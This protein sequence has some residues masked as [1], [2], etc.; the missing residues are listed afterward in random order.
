MTFDEEGGVIHVRLTPDPDV[1][2]TE[3]AHLP[4]LVLIRLTY[5]NLRR[6]HQ[7]R[8]TYGPIVTPLQTFRFRSVLKRTPSLR[9]ALVGADAGASSHRRIR[10]DGHLI[11]D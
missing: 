9:D 4:Q 3:L 2:A 11:S 6:D 10:R 5:A 1:V 7:N 8:T